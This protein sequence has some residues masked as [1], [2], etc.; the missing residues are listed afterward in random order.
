MPS[1]L[2]SA[3]PVTLLRKYRPAAIVRIAERKAATAAQGPFS[4]SHWGCSSLP[5]R[6]S[7]LTDPISVT[8]RGA[9]GAV[10]LGDRRAHRV[11]LGV[12]RL[13]DARQPLPERQHEIKRRS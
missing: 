7:T 12:L 13:D 2:S 6:A 5:T 1:T 11:V 10:A 8:G 4:R 9:H 3:L